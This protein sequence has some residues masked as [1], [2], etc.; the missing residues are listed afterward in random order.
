VAVTAADKAALRART[1]ADAVEMESGEILRACRAAGVPAAVVRVISDAADDELPLDF[2]TL[3]TPGGRLDG[4]RLALAVA[5]RPWRIPGLV[6]L[7]GRSVRAA[8]RLAEV[9]AALLA[10]PD[11]PWAEGKVRSAT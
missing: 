3:V 7:G 2:N 4:L 8:E 5:A 9:L 11:A 10:R 6:R 1:G